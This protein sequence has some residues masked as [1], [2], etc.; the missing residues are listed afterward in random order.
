M[1]RRRA[2][3]LVELLTVVAILS[4]LAAILFPVFSAVRAAARRAACMSN[5]RQIGMAVAL[6]RQ[7]Y[8]ALPPRLS[9]LARMV[10]GDPRVLV[11]PEDPKRGI[12]EGTDRM[13]GANFLSSG[14]SYDYV[15]RW[16]VAHELGWWRPP[17]DFGAGRW[18]ELT[19]LADCQWHWARAFH[20]NWSR[21]A[22]GAR[23]WQLVLTLGGA[24]R[25]L[26]VEDPVEEFTPERYR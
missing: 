3:T 18:E 12:H 6:Y 26:R 21:D 17:P 25:K 10:I 13:E 5:L 23:G 8:E 24:V 19:P 14:V 7:D 15:P 20:T 1:S 9:T 22:K 2:F 16:G 11:C 4:L